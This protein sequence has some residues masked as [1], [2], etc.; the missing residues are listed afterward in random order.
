M[1]GTIVTLGELMT[2]LKPPGKLRLRQASVLEVCHGGAEANVAVSLANFGLDVRF[3]SALPE[4]ELGEQA[5]AAMR[6]SGVDTTHVS[7]RPGRMG[8]YFMEEGADLR[9]GC[10]IYDRADSAFSGLAAQAINWDAVFDCASWFHISGITPAVSASTRDLA[11][12][13]VREAKA[14]GVPVSIDLNHRER[15]WAY[16]AKPTEVMPSLIE[17]ADTLVAGRGDCRACL[18]FDGKGEEGSNGWVESVADEARRRFPGLRNVAVTIRLSRTAE[19][20]AWRAFLQTPVASSF[21]RTYEMNHIVDRVGTGDAFCAG[22][23]YGLATGLDAETTVN[24]AAAANCLKHTIFGDANMVTAE[25]VRALA[26]T[27]S[28]GLLRR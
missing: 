23:L 5:L 24:F 27:S 14:R 16:G 7:R 22:L 1:T 28:F 2:R 20:H 9:S 25:E 4:G 13:S 18:G 6:A 10:V 19:V 21:S 8:L 15:L 17:M 26:A 3:V 12:A 11:V